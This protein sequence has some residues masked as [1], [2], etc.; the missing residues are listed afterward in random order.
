MRWNSEDILAVVLLA[1][2]AIG[3]TLWVLGVIP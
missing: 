1:A 3:F 2:W